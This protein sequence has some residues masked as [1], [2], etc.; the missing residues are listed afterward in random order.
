MHNASATDVAVNGY[1]R[2]SKLIFLFYRSLC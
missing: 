2:L 1:A